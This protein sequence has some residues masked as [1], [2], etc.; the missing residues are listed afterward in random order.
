MLERSNI[1]FRTKYFGVISPTS[2]L[3]SVIVMLYFHK[4]VLRWR[5]LSPKESKKSR[6]FLKDEFLCLYMLLFFFLICIVMNIILGF[7]ILFLI[8]C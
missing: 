8:V 6:D 5:Y 3:R 1:F 4:Y 7:Q 2:M